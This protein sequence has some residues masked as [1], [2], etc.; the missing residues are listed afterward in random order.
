MAKKLFFMMKQ[1][2][3]AKILCVVGAGHEEGLMSE[4]KKLYYSNISLV[5]EK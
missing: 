1:D 3:N 4:L 2:S 5:P